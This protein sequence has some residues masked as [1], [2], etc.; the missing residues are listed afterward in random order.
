MIT[1]LETM[2]LML[3]NAAEEEAR[4]FFGQGLRGRSSGSQTGEYIL[5]AAIVIIGLAAVIIAF[6]DKIAALFG[7]TTA[8]M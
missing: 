4:K 3:E 5:L 2:A 8:T 1:K 6:K 7:Q